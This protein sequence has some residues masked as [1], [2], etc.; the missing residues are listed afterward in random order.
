MLL[1]I[2]P[3][4]CLVQTDRSAAAERPWCELAFGQKGKDAI[5]PGATLAA[6]SDPYVLSRGPAHLLP[7]HA[8]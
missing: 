8:T 7:P 1:N 6:A 4:K 3:K 2:L 5:I